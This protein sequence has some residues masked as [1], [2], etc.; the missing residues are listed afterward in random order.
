V[1]LAERTGD[2]LLV[3]TQPTKGTTTFPAYV[4][5]TDG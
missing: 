4:L 5:D 1:L 2:Q 3:V